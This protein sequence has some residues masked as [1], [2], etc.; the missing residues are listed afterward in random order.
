M[1]AVDAYYRSFTAI[2]GPCKHA[3]TTAGG[4]A[5]CA[6]KREA[7]YANAGDPRTVWV[8]KIRLG[9]EVQLSADDLTDIAAGAGLRTRGMNDD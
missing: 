8:S 3:H 5:T 7:W 2:H 9:R 4:A 6:R 1:T